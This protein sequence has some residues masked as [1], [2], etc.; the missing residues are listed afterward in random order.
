M[1]NGGLGGFVCEE[2]GKEEAFVLEKRTG[3][4][5]GCIIGGPD[6]RLT[7]LSGMLLSRRC[8]Y[9]IRAALYLASLEQ[10]T[11]VSIREISEKLDLSF[12]F[13]TKIFQ[14]LTRAGLMRSFRGPNGGIALARP[15]A[16]ITLL[17]IV[18]AI[19]GPELFT[20]CVLGL[21]GCGSGDRKP[22]PLHASWGP[23]RDQLKT[24]FATETLA[25]FSDEIQRLD[26]RLTFF[27]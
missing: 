1:H 5:A 2:S 9:G 10:D 22:C 7:A 6:H 3:T 14:D 27:H 18:V 16:E 20:E 24:M 17:D 13:L 15:A 25:D 8:E 21:P 4:G 23:M 19:E 11:F 12:H 26:L